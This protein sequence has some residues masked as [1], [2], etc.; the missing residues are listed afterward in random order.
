MS[1]QVDNPSLPVPPSPPPRPWLL[2]IPFSAATP[3]LPRARN[4]YQKG[5][6]SSVVW[7]GDGARGCGAPVDQPYVCILR[8]CSNSCGEKERPSNNFV[9]DRGGNAKDGIVWFFAKI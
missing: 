3:P 2:Y 1:F 6:T 4:A 9:T 5:E 7:G 8:T